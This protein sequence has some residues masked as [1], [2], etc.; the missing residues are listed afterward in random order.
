MENLPVAEAWMK[1][2]CCSSCIN[3]PICQLNLSTRATT[4]KNKEPVE[5]TEKDDGKSDK[6][7]KSEKSEKSESKKLYYLCCFNCHWTSRCVFIKKMDHYKNLFIY[8]LNN[9]LYHTE[10]LVYLIKQVPHPH[11]QN[12]KILT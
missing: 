10:M 8:S 11:G 3:C 4:V 7:D 5:S 1:K 9:F 6:N 12:L 2:N